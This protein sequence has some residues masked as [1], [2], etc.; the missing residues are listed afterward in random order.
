MD[1]AAA[2]ATF[3]GGVFWDVTPFILAVTHQSTR[4][5]LPEITNLHSL[6]C[7]MFGQKFRNA[8]TKTKHEYSNAIQT[9]TVDASI[10]RLTKPRLA[11]DSCMIPNACSSRFKESLTCRFAVAACGT[12]SK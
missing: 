1:Q 2:A 6:T 11:T 10:Q 5:H 8:G 9:P 4:R 3:K 7:L 12:D